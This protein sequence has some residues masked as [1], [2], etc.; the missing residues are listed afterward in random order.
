MWIFDSYYKGCVELWGRERG[1]RKDSAAY[2]PSF[3]MH[4]KDPPAYREMIEALE[5]RF[6]AEECSFRTIFGTFPGHRIYASRKVAEK[7]EIQTRYAA[8]LY[9][10]DVRQD[11]RYL[12]EHDLFPCG[13][14]DKSRFSPDFEIPLTSLE[15]EVA[16]DPSLPGEITRV[17]VFNGRKRRLEG[18][19]REVLSDLMD[20]IKVHDPDL[21]LCPHA[22]T[23]VPI[24]V[25]KARR[26]GLEPTF[27]RTGFFKPM[28]SKSYWSYG[29][30]NHKDGAL[31]PEGRILI[32]TAKSFVYA[33]SGLKGILMASRLSGL[34]PNL[35]S[36]FTPG[37]LISSYEVFEALRR[38]VAVPFRKRDVEGLRNI[39]ELRA[40]D[41]GGMIFQPEPGVYE[42]VHQIDFTSMYPSIIVKYNL[43]PETV[44]DP[45]LKGF[46]C[47][48]LS[49]LLNLRIETKRLKK[50]NPDY[51]GIDSILKWMLVTC[52]GYTGYRNAKF[53]QIQVHERITEISRDLLVQIKEL[54]EGMNFQVLHGIVDCLWVIGEPIASFKE[55]VERET[56]I[57]TEVDSYDWI[58]FLPMADGSGAYNRYFG[59]L[60]AGKMKIRG[61]MARK[62]DTPEYVLRMQKE[63]FEVLAEAR[64]RE[65][66]RW[67]EPKARE[68]RR[69]Y[70]DELVEAD[71]RELAIHRRVSRLSYSRRC[72]EASA[73]QAHLKQG[74]PL[75]AGMEIGYVVKDAKKW[76]VEPERTAS[77]FDLGYYGK[78]LEKAWREVA[79]VFE[80]SD[81]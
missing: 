75:A 11:Q 45:E 26:Y 62:G 81:Q 3:Y 5:S 2:P 61:V 24:L 59:R 76:E 55:A 74:L 71:V 43:S 19:E 73:V 72:A 78:L 64:C 1:L 65:E 29:K 4:L 48:V 20:L 52:F 8:E 53:G 30:V 57:L 17:E 9:N 32:D 44:R 13:D 80:G 46:L 69:R 41:K 39:S 10:V 38:G 7:I 14:R 50:T 23:W 47:T 6:K 77:E 68:V 67:I 27:S 79:Y 28:A 12:A 66:L 33:E 54:A 15:I 51:A 42:R 36:R 31:I 34:S 21:I 70:M 63:I 60:K 49:S 25:R 40:C 22:D 37:T 58:A 35:T 56:G 16:G 18:S